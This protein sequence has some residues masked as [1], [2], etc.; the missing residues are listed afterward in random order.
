M[1]VV[2]ENVPAQSISFQY[3]LNFEKCFQGQETF[4]TKRSVISDRSLRRLQ[5]YLLASGMSVVCYFPNSSVLSKLSSLYLSHAHSPPPPH[6]I[7]IDL[8]HNFIPSV[9]FNGKFSQE[10]ELLQRGKSCEATSQCPSTFR[11]KQVETAPKLF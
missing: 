7:I 1:L 6:S 2:N 3:F 11:T 5:Q 9:P 4:K 8:S 10:I